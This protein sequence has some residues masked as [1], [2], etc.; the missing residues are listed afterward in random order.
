MQSNVPKK[1][2]IRRAFC[3]LTVPISHR[4]RME[5]K[6]HRKWKFYPETADAQCQIISTPIFPLDSD[7]RY[8]RVVYGIWILTR[9][10]PTIIALNHV[11]TAAI[12]L[13]II[14][15][16]PGSCGSPEANTFPS[17]WWPSPNGALGCYKPHDRKNSCCRSVTG[18]IS[19]SNSPV[20]PITHLQKP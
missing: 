17:K 5:L 10:K 2:Y 20:V 8:L 16:H 18:L 13:K 9:A 4:I 12:W 6:N 3:S 7:T 1:E 19:F 11:A 15:T 14:S